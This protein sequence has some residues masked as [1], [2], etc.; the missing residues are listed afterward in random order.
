MSASRWLW[1]LAVLTPALGVLLLALVVTQVW[2]IRQPLPPEVSRLRAQ[3]ALQASAQMQAGVPLQEV[4]RALGVDLRLAEGPPEGPPRVSSDWGPLEADW[5]PRELQGQTVWERPGPEHEAAAW[6]GSAWVVLHTDIDTEGLP[7][8]A[9][10]LLA[11]APLLAGTAWL[12]RRAARPVE[13]AEQAMARISAGDLET[14]L[15]ERAG[16]PELRRMARVVNSLTEETQR[17]VREER[18]RM[19]GLSHEMRTPL[20]RA[21]LELELARRAGAA[22]VDR[23]E[24]LDSELVALDALVAEL[25]ELAHLGSGRRSLRAEPVDL[26]SLMEALVEELGEERI[27]VHGQGEAHADPT[28]V[29][30]AVGNLLANARIHAPG[31][32]RSIH[33]DLGTVEVRDGG[34]G[35]SPQ[36]LEQATHPFWRG[37]PQAPGHGLGLAIVDD[38]ARLHGGRLVL[39]SEQG[40]RARLELPKTG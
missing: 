32:P 13:A 11:A 23:I 14:R 29:R 8:L 21:R 7:L 26:R 17:L 16:P 2:W 6:L 10:L 24:R 36:A 19:A 4:E 34:P 20:T 25:L 18:E 9:A 31:A 30:R 22:T 12:T 5:R 3:Q 38:I 33:V 35:M 27:S 40:L 37:D 1:P 15:D 28:L 39:T